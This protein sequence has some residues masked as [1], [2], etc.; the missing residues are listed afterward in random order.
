MSFSKILTTAL[1]LFNVLLTAEA[2]TFGLKWISAPQSDGLSPVWF[3]RTYTCLDDASTAFVT[4]VTTGHATLYVNGWNVSTDVIAPW[5]AFGDTDAVATTYDIKPFLQR[6]DNTLYVLYSPYV[7]R[8][9]SRQI[10]V[11]LYGCDAFGLKY[12]EQTDEDWLCCTASTVITTEGK[13]RTNG[14]ESRFPWADTNQG[15][16]RWNGAKSQIPDLDEAYACSSLMQKRWKVAHISQPK[17]VYDCDNNLICDFGDAFYGFVRVTIRDAKPG[18]RIN[19]GGLEYVCN[20]ESDEQAYGRFAPSS[21]RVVEITGD[22][23]FAVEQI[24]SVE[25]IGISACDADFAF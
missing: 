21:Y 4:L 17:Q 19:I 5:H 18:E 25:G 9:E 2:Q 13:E 12:S 11:Q 7:G 15:L 24:V 23:N 22:K 1:V 10:A 6:G 20:G 3:R 8:E 14:L 16:A